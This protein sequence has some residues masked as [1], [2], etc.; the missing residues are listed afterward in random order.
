MNLCLNDQGGCIE[1]VGYDSYWV[2]GDTALSR[3][4]HPVSWGI[5]DGNVSR[6]VFFL[7]PVFSTIQGKTM[8]GICWFVPMP[9]FYAE[10]RGWSKD[11]AKRWAS[12]WSKP[13]WL[14]NRVS[15]ARVVVEASRLRRRG[16]QRL[17]PAQKR[18]VWVLARSTR[19]SCA[20]ALPQELGYWFCSQNLR[21]CSGIA[22][23]SDCQMTGREWLSDD[24]HELELGL[25]LE[26]CRLT[27]G[28]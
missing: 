16:Q 17:L 13:F 1:R 3:N 9:Y 24:W 2:L 23:G 14:P 22:F 21:Y 19:P 8:A 27:N 7:S 20:G 5:Q 6:L 18:P 15:I 10:T 4:F 12:L 28:L 26:V 25:K 11:W